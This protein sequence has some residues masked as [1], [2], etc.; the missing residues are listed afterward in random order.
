MPIEVRAA[1]V[2]DDVATMVGPKRPDANVCWCLS[3]RV[4]SKEN[5]SLRGTAR[6]ERVRELVAEPL[7]PG[8][9]AYE[10]DE[11]VGWAAVH[12]RA[13]T[14]FATN[15]RI[16]H[17]DDLDV[18]SVWCLRIRPGYRKRGLSHPL[19]AGAVEFARANGA[20]AIEGYP[21][22]NAGAKVDL[23]MA[24]VGTRALFERAGF[25]KAADTDSVVGGFPRVVMRLDLR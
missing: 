14:S 10:G 3:Y 21:V 18:W 24:Y 20:P 25:E 7:A 6:G 2:F 16:P 4:G 11:P 5:L 13:A 23:T 8:V 15:R 17:V 9:I 1:S 22:D 19:L 12:P